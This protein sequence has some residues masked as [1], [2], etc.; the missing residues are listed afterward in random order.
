MSF[1]ENE[2][3]DAGVNTDDVSAQLADLDGLESAI[4]DYDE[5]GGIEAYRC[6]L[7]DGHEAGLALSVPVRH[8]RAIKEHTERILARHAGFVKQSMAR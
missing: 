7:A 1:V 5:A 3:E 8:L 2:A 6:F 4:G